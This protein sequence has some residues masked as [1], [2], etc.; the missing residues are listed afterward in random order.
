MMPEEARQYWFY[1]PIGIVIDIVNG[2]HRS[3]LLKQFLLALLL[4]LALQAQPAG[5]QQMPLPCVIGS[6]TQKLDEAIWKKI[7]NLDHAVAYARYARMLTACHAE[8]AIRRITAMQDELVKSFTFSVKESG[9]ND[10]LRNELTGRNGSELGSPAR[11]STLLTLKGR[12]QTHLP[13]GPDGQDAA[14]LKY[15]C[16][17]GF[18]NSVSNA[19]NIEA[20][21][22][23]D[24]EDC[25][26][27]PVNDKPAINML[28]AAFRATGRYGAAVAFKVECMREPNQ[29]AEWKDCDERAAQL[30]SRISRLRVNVV[31]LTVTQIAEAPT[32]ERVT[33][34]E[35]NLVP[36]LNGLYVGDIDVRSGAECT[37]NDGVVLGHVLVGNDA[38]LYALDTS[39]IGNVVATGAKQVRFNYPKDRAPRQRQK[40]DANAAERFVTG[41]VEMQNGRLIGQSA[42]VDG[43]LIGRDLNI[44]G[45]TGVNR[46]AAVVL[47]TSN[48]CNK[49]LVIG[50]RI[51][52]RDNREGLLVAINNTFAY[53]N[54]TCVGNIVPVEMPL[55]PPQDFDNP[56][57]KWPASNVQTRQG[58]DE[59]AGYAG[60]FGVGE[61]GGAELSKTPKAEGTKAGRRKR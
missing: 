60:A 21:D 40:P 22:R 59:C 1:K 45:N 49:S 27:M 55:N 38:A 48:W 12:F 7:R 16:S 33:L 8:T 4:P 28:S 47:C 61:R 36:N 39:V 25:G 58:F 37:L 29:S 31:R 43:L 53:G 3:R 11:T 34:C 24:G 44:V 5:A 15:R 14:S 57:L 50:G 54:L 26:G 51:S 35:G 30:G 2:S 56:D 23:K 17:Y 13:T 32:S 6:P 52:V 46:T 18:N 41:S 9:S 10:E 20:A 19:V 42:F